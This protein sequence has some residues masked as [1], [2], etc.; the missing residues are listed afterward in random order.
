MFHYHEKKRKKYFSNLNKK[1]IT[2]KKKLWQTIK[3]FV[4]EK[5]KSRKKITLIEDENL[6]S[7]DVKVANCVNN[8][9]SNIV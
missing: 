6:V 1:D 4:S 3:P 8:F 2:V 9:F 5:T 7:D